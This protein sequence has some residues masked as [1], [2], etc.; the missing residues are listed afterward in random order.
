MAKTSAGKPKQT[1]L[2][3]QGGGAL[4]AYQGGVYEEL[5]ANRIN[6]DWIAGISIG[7]INA[8]IIAGNPPDKRV[9]KLKSFWM[10][11]SAGKPGE[12]I[13]GTLLSRTLT[14]EAAAAWVTA[15]GVPGFFAPRML[16]PSL[17]LSSPAATLG[18]YDTS[19]LRRTLKEHVD[20]GR[21][22]NEGK[23]RV[24]MGSVD[25]KTGNFAYFDNV[26]QQ[27]GP[28][29]VMAAG[30]L[31]PGLPPVEIEGKF[32]WDGGLVS[33]TPLEYVMDEK[34]WDG[35]ALVLQVDLF[36]AQGTVPRTMFDVFEREKDIR[37][38]SRTRLNTDVF[39]RRQILGTA[40]RNLLAKLPKKLKND[41]DAKLLME[42]APPQGCVS[43]V[44]LIYRSKLFEGPAKDYVFTHQAVREHW[45][46]GQ[47]DI[48]RS[49]HHPMLPTRGAVAAGVTEFDPTREEIGPAVAKPPHL[50]HMLGSAGGANEN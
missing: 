22:N 32:Y 24:S 13:I 6:V 15:F 4:G 45:A 41:P 30:A 50:P 34:T 44:H 29:H 39:R 43:I 11:V 17:N 33:N 26:R 46:A 12:S 36:S 20:F 25:I 35:D 5:A 42:A 19:P 37:Y 38:S 8:A 23:M 40:L 2:L 47:F 16:P 49:L 48:R 10:S 7:A 18:F 27:I 28:E 31:P 21:I 14:N 3:L 9:D 1:I